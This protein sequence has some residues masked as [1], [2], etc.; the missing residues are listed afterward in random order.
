MNIKKFRNFEDIYPEKIEG[1]DSWYYGQWTPCSDP[2]DVPDYKDYPGTRLYF[3]EYPSGKV[4]EPIKQEKNVFLDRPVYE[5]KDNTFGILKYDFNK[6]IVQILIYSPSNSNIEV[7][8][9]M[10]L[11]KLKNMVSVNLIT[12]PFTLIKHDIQ[13]NCVDFLWPKEMHIKL[14]ENET[15]C[16][17]SDGK[18]YTSRWFEDTDYHEEIIIRDGETGEILERNLGYFRKMADGSL[19]MMTS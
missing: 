6:K 17:Q 9:E 7:I 11:S 1:T 14:E 4:F 18:I 2:E 19:W 15:L 12:S 3:F 5:S 8:A 10:P 16:F 13:N